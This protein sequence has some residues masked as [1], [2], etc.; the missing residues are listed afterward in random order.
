MAVLETKRAV[1]L[2]LTPTFVAQVFLLV[3]STSNLHTSSSLEREVFAI[4]LRC[5]LLGRIQLDFWHHST[6]SLYVLGSALILI[7]GN[8]N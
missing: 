1:S 7:E 2:L 5:L 3:S 8:K 4:P 6:S